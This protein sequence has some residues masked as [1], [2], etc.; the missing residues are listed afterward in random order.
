MR[1]MTH[2]SKPKTFQEATF[3]RDI[4]VIAAFMARL[5]IVALLYNVGRGPGFGTGDSFEEAWTNTDI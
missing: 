5:G 3:G 2:Q 1:F 4:E